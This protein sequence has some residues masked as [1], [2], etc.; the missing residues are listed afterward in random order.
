MKNERNGIKTSQRGNKSVTSQKT[1]LNIYNQKVSVPEPL[2]FKLPRGGTKFMHKRHKSTLFNR[3]NPN[4]TG[5]ES[6]RMGPTENQS[7]SFIT[8]GTKLIKEARKQTT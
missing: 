1:F 7:G 2:L 8:T 5:Q 6:N 4:L 3:T